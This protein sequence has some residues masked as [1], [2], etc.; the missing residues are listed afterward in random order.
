MVRSA[1]SAEGRYLASAIAAQTQPGQNPQIKVR[2]VA[3]KFLALAKRIA[4]HKKGSKPGKPT[5]RPARKNK[6]VT[7]RGVLLLCG[8]LLGFQQMSAG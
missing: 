3:P 8:R 5:T 4:A 2:Y 6:A 7:A 1:P